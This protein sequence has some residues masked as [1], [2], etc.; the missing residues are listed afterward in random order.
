LRKS[1]QTARQP[2]SRRSSIGVGVAPPLPVEP[3]FVL[4]AE[5]RQIPSLVVNLMAESI[6]GAFGLACLLVVLTQVFRR[7]ALALMVIL[8]LFTT[9][10]PGREVFVDAA[11]L[12]SLGSASVRLPS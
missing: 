11:P 5:P 10:W 6:T 12:N 8:V 9:I 3:D 7:R 4:L 2:S 1:S